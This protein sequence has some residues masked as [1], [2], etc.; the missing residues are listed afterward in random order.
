MKQAV[1]LA[2]NHATGDIPEKG[3]GYEVVACSVGD[4]VFGSVNENGTEVGKRRKP[5]E[6]RKQ[7][8]GTR[9]TRSRKRR[10]V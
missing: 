1:Y 7:S 8:A 10:R 2:K 4:S 5:V 9:E 3:D 6:K